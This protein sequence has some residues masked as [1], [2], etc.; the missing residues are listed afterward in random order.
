MPVSILAE[1]PDDDPLPHGETWKRLAELAG[2]RDVREMGKP[3]TLLGYRGKNKPRPTQLKAAALAYPLEGKTILL[4]RRIA[5][6]FG[7]KGEYLKWFNHGSAEF[8][9]VPHPSTLSAWWK[10]SRNLERG[11]AFLR[12]L[13]VAGGVTFEAR[14]VEGLS[15]RERVNL[16]GN[17]WDRRGQEGNAAYNAFSI[18]LEL[19]YV[20]SIPKV[21]K[22]LGLSSNSQLHTWKKDHDWNERCRAWDSYELNISLERRAESREA[23][24]QVLF[25]AAVD[26]ATI[27]VQAAK[28]EMTKDPGKIQPSTRVAAAQKGLELC[29][30]VPP[31]RIEMTHKDERNLK[32]AAK[33][34]EKVDDIDVIRRMAY[35]ETAAEAGAELH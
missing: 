28:G 26:L 4:G 17:P 33:A 35:G 5:T 31:K 20:R 23:A 11:R 3:I 9:I 19:G 29:G 13:A 6:A 30:L 32:K 27:L 12:A 18:Y 2:V 25:D 10:N 22:E 21:Q 34:V 24:R 1:C 8:C 7:A 14:S 16:S 15:P